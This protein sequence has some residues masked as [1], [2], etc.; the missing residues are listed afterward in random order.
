MLKPYYEHKGITIYHGD[1]R[2]ILERRLLPEWGTFGQG[3]E[4]VVTDPPYGMDYH[5]GYYK[6]GNPHEKVIGDESFPWEAINECRSMATVGV[7]A[8]CRWDN[9]VDLE[10]QPKSY[11]VWAKNNWTAGDLEHAHG[12]MWEGVA[13][14][15]GPNHKFTR[16]APDVLKFDRVSPTHLQHPTEK[17]VGLIR[18]LIECNVCST[19]LDPFMGSGTTLRAAKDLGRSA[20]GIEIE[21]KYCEIAANRLGQDVFGF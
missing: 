16:R 12:R 7:Y 2:E 3:V 5:S 21:E 17:P 11:L 9:I 14:W 19:I 18:E 10:V 4:L 13:W 1:S 6:Y 20:I 15:P 8:F